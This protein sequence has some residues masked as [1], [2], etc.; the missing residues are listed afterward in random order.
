MILIMIMVI[1][2][3]II[4]IIFNN[5]SERIVLNAATIFYTLQRLNCDRLMK[6]KQYF[7]SVLSVGKYIFG[8]T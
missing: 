8:Y 4:I 5:R 7:M 2:I 3:I 1:I 6:G